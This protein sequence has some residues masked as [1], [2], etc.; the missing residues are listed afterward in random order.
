MGI[1]EAVRARLLELCDE[2]K[3]TVN[4]MCYLSAV[5]QSTVNNFINGKTAN[6]GIVTLKKRIDG[7][8]LT[9]EEFYD[10]EVFRQLEQEIH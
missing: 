8:G 3:I 9:L 5:P 1:V 6:M 4:R 7:L 2:K 10:A